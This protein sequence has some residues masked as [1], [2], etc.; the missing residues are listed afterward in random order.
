[1]STRAEILRLLSDGAFHS[2]T[3]LGNKLGITRAAVCKCIRH[4]TQSGLERARRI[5]LERRRLWGAAEAAAEQ[6]RHRNALL[7]DKPK[8]GDCIRRLRRFPQILRM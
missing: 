8:N 6:D 4:L 2:G 7:M 3:D 5:F 1:M